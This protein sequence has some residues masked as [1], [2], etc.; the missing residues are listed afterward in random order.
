M[1][2]NSV[3]HLL[4]ILT[5]SKIKIHPFSLQYLVHLRHPFNINF[6]LLKSVYSKNLSKLKFLLDNNHLHNRLFQLSDQFLYTFL[7][8]LLISIMKFL[9]H[10]ILLFYIIQLNYSKMKHMKDDFLRKYFFKPFELICLK[11]ILS[12][13]FLIIHKI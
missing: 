5:T 11:Q 7:L 1:L 9:S 6:H 12:H 10:N 3:C 2:F 13:N 8:F 4:I